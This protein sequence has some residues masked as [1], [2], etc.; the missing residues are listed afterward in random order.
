MSCEDRRKER[1]CH[2]KEG[3]MGG[4]IKGHPP[5]APFDDCSRADS[6]FD[7]GFFY[8]GV[9]GSFSLMQKCDNAIKRY[10]C[11]QRLVFEKQSN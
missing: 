8:S 11:C 4:E 9:G 6:K 7:L 3:F 5:A 1:V 2:C 10:L